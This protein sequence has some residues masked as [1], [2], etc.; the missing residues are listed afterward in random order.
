MHISPLRE[1]GYSRFAGVPGP[2]CPHGTTGN[3][4]SAAIM[5]VIISSYQKTAYCWTDDHDCCPLFLAK[6]LRGN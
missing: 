2:T 4:C 3:F 5:T 6:A 1:E